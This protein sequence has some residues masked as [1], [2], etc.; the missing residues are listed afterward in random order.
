MKVNGNKLT[1]VMSGLGYTGLSYK[2]THLI[3]HLVE[4]YNKMYDM[5]NCDP[6]H[7]FTL[8]FNAFVEAKLGEKIQAFRNNVDGIFSD[9]G[10]LQIVTQGAILTP[11]TKNMIY[12]RQAKFS[13]LAMSFD[14]IPVKFLGEK[15][16]RNDMASRWFDV[17]GFEQ[18]ARTSGQN[19]K[20]QIDAFENFNSDTKPLLICQGNDYDSYMK[21]TDYIL[22]ELPDDY[23]ER[24]GGVA[25]GAAALGAGILEDIKRVFFYSLI[26]ERVKTAKRLHL[27]GVGSLIRILPTLIFMKSGVLSDH[28]VTYDS[29]TH[30][31]CIH[32]GNYY[33]DNKMHQISRTAPVD[34]WQWVSDDIRKN[35]GAD[36]FTFDGEKAREAMT[37]TSSVYSEKYGSR[38]DVCITYLC[39]GLSTT[40][41]FMNEVDSVLLDD[42]NAS[43]DR[44]A[45]KTKS[46]HIFRTLKEVRTIDDF[47]RWETEMH[48]NRQVTKWSV[49]VAAKKPACL[50]NFF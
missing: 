44:I 36:N 19:L 15:S 24:I 32:N 34:R 18:A 27:L 23:V 45:K 46:T 9:S 41:N 12:E 20:E 42:T 30:S 13:D 31:S 8:L 47:V 14:E 1:Y 11:N 29:T 28:N 10:G 25:M 4:Y 43:I 7:T 50:S 6:D 35:L 2:D 40:K 39:M 5:M 17:D 49:P 33:Q 21:W 16:T 26:S 38:D 37:T 3:P 22:E 48:R